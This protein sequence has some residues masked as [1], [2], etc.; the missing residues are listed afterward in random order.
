MPAPKPWTVRSSRTVVADRW[1]DLRAETVVNGKG[2]TLDPFYVLHYADWVHVFAVTTEGMVVLTEQYRAGTARRRHRPDRPRP[3][4]GRSA[5]TAG[6]NGVRGGAA[7]PGGGAGVEPRDAQ[8]PRA[9]VPGD[10]V[11]RVTGASAG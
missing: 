5:G 6:G 7:A 1:I 10:G 2:V 4:L 9:Y 11:P 8:Q 3:R